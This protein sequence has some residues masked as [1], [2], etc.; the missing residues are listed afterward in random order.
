[1][2]CPFNTMTWISNQNLLS[3]GSCFS[4]PNV[5]CKNKTSKQT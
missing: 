2:P 5:L 1:M 3:S 4:F